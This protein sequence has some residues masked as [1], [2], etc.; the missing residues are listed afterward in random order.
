MIQA[1]DT[2]PATLLRPQLPRPLTLFGGLMASGLVHIGVPL[3][4]WWFFQD[5]GN[6]TSRRP[7]MDADA[8]IEARFVQL[9]KPIDPSQLPN[10]IAPQLEAATPEGVVVS[11]DPRIAA[12]PPDAGVPPPPRVTESL[13]RRLGDRAKAFAEMEA[14]QE[15]EGDPNG[16]A[17]GTATE[18]RGGDLYRGQLYVF[19]RRNWMLPTVLSDEERDRLVTEIDL[20]IG[21]DLGIR[22]FEVRRSSGNALFDQSVVEMLSNLQKSRVTVPPPPSEVAGQFIGRTLGL[23]FRGS[24]LR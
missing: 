14:R 10:R 1:D 16:I 5:A 11:E 4:I 24:D 12:T 22:N 18:A 15:R 21:E 9:G 7:L 3:S 17:E 6:T 13:V 19:F 8:V 23:R 20:R 2:Q